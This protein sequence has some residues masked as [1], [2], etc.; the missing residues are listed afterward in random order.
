[1]SYFKCYLS[2]DVAGLLLNMHRS[3]IHDVNASIFF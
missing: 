3:Q 1:M 2:F